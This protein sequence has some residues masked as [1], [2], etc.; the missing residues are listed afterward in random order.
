MMFIQRIRNCELGI[1]NLFDCASIKIPLAQGF[2][3]SAKGVA[4]ASR[5]S[6]GMIAFCIL[7]FSGC[8]TPYSPKPKSYFRIDLPEKSYRE[9]ASPVCPFRF[10]YPAYADIVRDSTFFNEPTENPCWLNIDFKEL[11]G[12]IHLSYKQI[13]EKNSFEKLLEDA[14]KLTFKHTMKADFIDEN[15]IQ[16]EHGVSGILFEVGGNAASNAQFFLTDSVH[17]FIRGSLYFSSTPNEDSLAP[18]IRFVKEDMLQMMKSFEWVD[19]ERK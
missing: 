18:V 3:V 7:L 1:S 19:G 12:K 15:A 5:V 6:G 17:H 14:H 2:A 16:N 4:F 13:D 10:Q 9:Y 8:D 11:R